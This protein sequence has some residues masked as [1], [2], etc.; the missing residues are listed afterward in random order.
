VLDKKPVNF[1]HRYSL[2]SRLKNYYLLAIVSKRHMMTI[3]CA[4]L[5]RP[6]LNSPCGWVRFVSMS[7]KNSDFTSM[8]YHFCQSKC[9]PLIPFI[10]FC[11]QACYWEV[12]QTLECLYWTLWI[13]QSCFSVNWRVGNQAVFEEYF[14][15]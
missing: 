5:K 15:Y 2:Y 3:H 14:R 4:K 8:I 12:Q 11:F 10:L 9:I 13:W 1:W 7:R 6:I